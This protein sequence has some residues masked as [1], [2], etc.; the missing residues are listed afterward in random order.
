MELDLILMLV[1]VVNEVYGVTD[2]ML[3]K[4]ILAQHEIPWF[5]I[6]DLVLC[7][8]CSGNFSIRFWRQWVHYLPQ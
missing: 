4:N 8:Q 5:Y 2:L 1:I 7:Y 6:A 3:S